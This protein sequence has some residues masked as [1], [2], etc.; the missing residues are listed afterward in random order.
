[1]KFICGEYF[2]E[3]SRYV[4]DN[5]YLNFTEGV[6]IPKGQENL[7]IQHNK[8]I[9]YEN[10]NTSNYIFAN[11]SYLKEA[12]EFVQN[13]DAD[14]ILITHKLDSTI[15]DSFINKQGVSF[16]DIINN[17]KIKHWYAQNACT[18]NS[19]LTYIPI[20]IECPRIELDRIIEK[21]NWQNTDR[22]NNFLINFNGDVSYSINNERSI[23]KN[24]LIQKNIYKNKFNFFNRKEFINDMTNSYFCLSP[25][26]AGIDCHRTWCAL[27]CGTIPILT[28]NYISEK[29]ASVF[30]VL[31]IDKW[32]DLNL[33]I[34]NKELYFNI[35]QNKLEI[36]NL[37]LNNFI[38]ILNIF[39]E[40][41]NSINSI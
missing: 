39:N 9:F 1:M 17:H 8:F 26:G 23:L 28:K 35:K 32:E 36:N 11:P 33:N 21:S 7:N 41:T 2:A 5:G 10:K 34:L 25:M 37:N 12:L 29:I 40:N 15:N 6:Y 16:L 27:Y 20:G 38:D 22:K 18:K 3:N 24:I 31:L 4:F 13:S 14:F 30:P 19:K